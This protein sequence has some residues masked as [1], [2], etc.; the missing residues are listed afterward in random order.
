MIKS[1][2]NDIKDDTMKVYLYTYAYDQ[3]KKDGYKSLAMF[4]KNNEDI[5]ERLMIHKSS[6]KSENPDD[7]I[8]YLE[9]TFEGRLRSICV[10]SEMAPV[11][12]YKHPYLNWLVHHADVL[13]FDLDKLIADGLVEGVYCKDL[14]ETI[15]VDSSLENIYKIK[16]I[17]DIDLTP[18]DW[19]LCGGDEYIKYSPWA[20]IKHYFL[21]LTKGYI[22]PEYITLEL[23]NSK[24]R[25]ADKL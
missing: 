23:D 25:E 17:N 13:S 4:Y 20:T 15:L 6:A 2:T 12:E 7:I 11:E 18:Y 19:H 8:A 24:A 22:P 21:V 1:N 16:D 9:Q 5:K 10:V 3:I 14:R